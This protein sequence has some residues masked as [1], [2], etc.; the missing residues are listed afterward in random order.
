MLSIDIHQRVSDTPYSTFVA[1]KKITIGDAFEAIFQLTCSDA[2][3][4]TFIEKSVIDLILSNIQNRQTLSSDFAYVLE[5]LNKNLRELQAQYDLTG[6]RIFFGIMLGDDLHFSVRGHY[7]VA[8]VKDGDAV[9][10]ASGM[11]GDAGDFSYISSG[12]VHVG[13]TLFISNLP[14]AH[15]LTQDDMVELSRISYSPDRTSSIIHTLIDHEIGPENFAVVVITHPQPVAPVEARPSIVLQYV[16]GRYEVVSNIVR[17]TQWLAPLRTLVAH[18]PDRIRGRIRVGFFVVGVMVSIGL[19]Y[20]IIQAIFIQR[21]HDAMPEEYKNKLI[22]A[23]LI[24]EK[25]NKNI[26]NR[27]ALSVDIK[28]AEDLIFEVRDKQLYLNDVKKLLGDISI[29]KRQMDGIESFTV[30]PE[31]TIYAFKVPRQVVGIFED[32]KKLYFV[33]KDE[34]MGPYIAGEDMRVSPYP[35]GE[36]A[37][38]TDLDSG[39]ISILTKSNRVL[40]YSKGQF[41]YATVTGQKTW[42]P[43]KTLHLYNGNVYLLGDDGHQIWKHK[44]GPNGY[45][46]KSGV[47]PDTETKSAT[48]MLLDLVVD[49]GFYLLGRDLTLSRMATSPT[50]TRRSIIIN[51]LPKDE[52]SI[53]DG[54][55]APRLL[56]GNN[57]YYVYM[58]LNNRIWVFEPNSK[59]A[60]DVNAVK[61]IGQIDTSEGTI[62]SAY[63]QKDGIVY[64][65]MKSGIYKVN[66]EVVDGKI[67]VK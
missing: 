23:Q 51:S 10:I 11:E 31:R 17:E 29:L 39:V 46:V 37:I 1:S 4:G 19:L 63:I 14:L 53:L 34:V 24:I 55:S 62:D 48:G 66:F 64:V 20:M 65:G 43:S 22:E 15:H 16:Q 5:R 12:M 36:E 8:L 2:S 18:I 21:V 52:Y 41:T 7:F 45:S 54:T 58:L 44:P 56:L 13:S 6:L 38:S 50:Y 57:G 25:A 35:D 49:G 28:H 40:R 3:L 30:T 60:K 9:E 67:V 27:E 42:E 26:S 47:L 32:N 61:Y 59:N 33:G